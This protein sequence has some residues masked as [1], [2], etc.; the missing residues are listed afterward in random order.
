MS[1]AKILLQDSAW[2]REGHFIYISF[3]FL[4]TV[5]GPEVAI[6]GSGIFSD[7]F[8]LHPTYTNANNSNY[9]YNKYNN[10]SKVRIA[11]LP[12][13]LIPSLSILLNKTQ[14]QHRLCC[15]SLFA[16]AFK[17]WNRLKS[18]LLKCQQS[19]WQCCSSYYSSAAGPDRLD[20]IIASSHK[21]LLL[22]LIS[23]VLHHS[24][25]HHHG[26]T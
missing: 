1:E 25:Q 22:A 8:F 7:T 18:A 16:S 12:S 23:W 20:E 4:L 26:K 10:I 9:K 21:H 6:P 15:V 2:Q 13:I 17:P 19:L 11:F 5:L 24:S 14:E 3:A